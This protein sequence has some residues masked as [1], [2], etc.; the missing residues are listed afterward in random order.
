MTTPLVLTE[1]AGHVATITMNRPGKLN[2][3]SYELHDQLD[4]ALVAA[5]RDPEVRCVVLTGAGKNFCVGDDV[6]SAWS[7]DRFDDL[8][9]E[10]GSVHP[11]PE[12]N[13]SRA[14]VEMRTPIVAAVDGYCWGMGFEV[15][16]W[17]DIIIATDRASFNA[18]EIKYAV[19]A[20]GHTFHALPKLVGKQQ[21]ALLL[22]TGDTITADRAASLGLVAEVVAPDDLLERACTIAAAISAHAPQAIEHTK[23]ALKLATDTTVAGLDRLFVFTSNAH[24][25]LFASEDHKEAAAAYVEKRDPLYT[26]R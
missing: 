4:A 19:V 1:T 23:E 10:L 16:L 15:A 2:A 25:R 7:G 26:G 5:D 21:A 20:G 18:M 6:Q 13:V 14:G 3:L 17:A 9:A 12:R 11:R 24:A 8:M 22:L